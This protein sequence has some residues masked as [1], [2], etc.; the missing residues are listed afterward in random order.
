[1][2][3]FARVYILTNSQNLTRERTRKRGTSL[4]CQRVKELKRE[5]KK[6]KVSK[7][8][9]RRKKSKIVGKEGENLGKP[10]GMQV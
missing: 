10:G 3:P 5:K 2:S 8:G 4:A 6:E 7:R 9:K 1:M